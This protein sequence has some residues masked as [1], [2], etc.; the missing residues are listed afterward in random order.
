[1][2]LFRYSLYSLAGILGACWIPGLQGYS[3]WVAATSIIVLVLATLYGKSRIQEVGIGLF[4]FSLLPTAL[5][6]SVFPKGL[7]QQ[8][9]RGTFDFEVRTDSPSGALITR[10][11]NDSVVHFLAVDELPESRNLEK[12]VKYRGIGTIRPFPPRKNPWGFDRS[13]YLRLKG[14][15]GLIDVKAFRSLDTLRSTGK[16]PPYRR[17]RST[18]RKLVAEITPVEWQQGLLEALLLGEKAGLDPS[19]RRLFNRAGTGHVLAVSGLHTGLVFAFL[20]L[21]LRPV[22]RLARGRPLSGLLALL[23]LLAFGSIV[24][25][26]PSV[27]RAITMCAAWAVARFGRIHTDGY[28]VYSLALF[29]SILL[30]PVS[31]FE[32]GFQLSFAAVLAIIWGNKT[33][34]R[35]FHGR[36]WKKWQKGLVGSLWISLCA[37]LGTLPLVMYYFGSLPMLFLPANL[38]LLPLLP[39]LLAWGYLA[40][41][42]QGLG[43]FPAKMKVLTTHGLDLLREG[44]LVFDRLPEGFFYENSWSLS[45]VFMAYALGIS[46]ALLWDRPSYKRRMLFGLIA[47]SALAASTHLR[48]RQTEEKWIL[49]PHEHGQSTL[50]YA[51][52]GQLTLYGQRPWRLELDRRLKSWIGRRGQESL[53]GGPTANAYTLGATGYLIALDRSHWVI[54]DG[55]NTQILWLR[56]GSWIHLEKL[57]SSHSVG[58]V[59]A[60]GSNRG[61]DLERWE[62]SCRKL[63]VPFHRTDRDGYFEYRY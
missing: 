37:Q 52:G 56:E 6:T 9:Y 18:L 42:L 50:L 57:L 28:A 45:Y 36:K 32:P 17:I 34:N 7:V 58:Q 27:S 26:G 35:W 49:I 38:I 14:A 10:V 54:P 43:A 31:V 55:V 15:S 16:I 44:L 29:G 48:M 21:L 40:L 13:G 12:G 62:G 51:K 39:F 5:P 53:F 3:R 41:L 4:L 25:A 47:G 59:V 19:T 23:P 11:W 22:D 61:L 8:E 60:D 33:L 24:G 2:P 63:G 20:S 30:S 46:A 1:M